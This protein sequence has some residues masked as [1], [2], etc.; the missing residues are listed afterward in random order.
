[1][2]NNQNIVEQEMGMSLNDKPEERH[3]VRLYVIT[4][5]LV[6]LN[7]AVFLISEIMGNTLYSKG[8][9]SIL[10]LLR[11]KEY[12]RILTALFLHADIHH[13]VNN[14]LL[15]F[16]MGKIVEKQVGH[17]RFLIIYLLSGIGGNLFSGCWELILGSY[18]SSI[19]A[20]GAVF[21]VNG[22]LLI[23]VFLKNGPVENISRRGILLMTALSVYNGF[24]VENINNAAHIGGLM[25]GLLV[26]FIVSAGRIK[27]EN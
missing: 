8:A 11:D 21:G 20:S 3:N 23:L 6:V 18:F 16:F 5:L 27:H 2:D 19:G 1:M 25:I 17:A 7:I 22:A 14:M 15:L 4:L 26:T 9:F 10:L 24:T 12:Y 13:I